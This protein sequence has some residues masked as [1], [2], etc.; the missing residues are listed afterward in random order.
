MAYNDVCH[1]Q[2]ISL[3]QEQKSKKIN[4][5]IPKQEMQD[6]IVELKT[7]E[8]NDDEEFFEFYNDEETCELDVD[9][10]GESYGHDEED[11]SCSSR[12]V[13][14]IEEEKHEGLEGDGDVSL[15]ADE[16]NKLA[17]DFI[18]RIIRQRMLEAEFSR[19]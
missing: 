12:E 6:K 7:C 19:G 5:N 9:Q 10:L 14:V 2:I 18:A 11:L 16:L 8:E 1:P 13:K 15:P 4:K 3:S 17:D